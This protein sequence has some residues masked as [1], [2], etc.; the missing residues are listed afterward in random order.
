MHSVLV[1]PSV[2]PRFWIFMYR[3]T[4]LSYYISAIM[5]TGL[6]GSRITCAASD[7]LRV[8]PPLGQTCGAYLGSPALNIL[9]ESATT[10]CEVCAY[11]TA[12]AL[13]AYFGMNFNER[14]W[15]WGVTVAYNIGNIA[16]AILLYWVVRVPKGTKS[17][18]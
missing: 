3:V 2:L 11:D 4:P 1:P 14:W 15:Q 12:D 10:A 13:L 16:L 7:I 8:E 6:S 9:N 5:S 18:L 17:T